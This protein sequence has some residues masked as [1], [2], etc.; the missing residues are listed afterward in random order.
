MTPLHLR[1]RVRRLPAGEV[2]VRVTVLLL[3]AVFIVLGLLAIVLPGPLTIPPVLLGLAIWSLEFEFARRWFERAM[4]P[5]RK[6]WVEAKA[7]PWRTGVITGGGLVL[8]VAAAALVA[9]LGLVDSAR[10]ALG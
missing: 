2:I 7:H 9:H 1:D 6:A 8:M 10:D 4:V 3:G 5:G